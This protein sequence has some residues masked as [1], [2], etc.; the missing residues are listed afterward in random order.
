MTSKKRKRAG[1]TDIDSSKK[2]KGEA[3]EC[4]IRPIA[5]EGTLVP[6]KDEYDDSFSSDLSDE[7]DEATSDKGQSSNEPNTDSIEPLELK[8]NNANAAF[9]TASL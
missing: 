7:S 1:A 3:N 9:N 8:L 5:F 6:P 2:L 4:D